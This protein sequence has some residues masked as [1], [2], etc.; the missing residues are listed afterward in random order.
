MIK[1]GRM[2][3]RI[4]SGKE[5]REALPMKEAI[6]VMANAFGQ[7]SRGNAEVPLRGKLATEEGVTLL[8]S[9]YLKQRKE[10]GIKI[11]SIYEKNPDLGLPVVSAVVLVLDPQTGFPKALMDGSTLT[12][13]RTGAGGGLAARLLSR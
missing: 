4:L 10:F 5:G 3:I 6:E 2:K 13:I 7:L 1:G 8:M 9:A 12:A 11:V